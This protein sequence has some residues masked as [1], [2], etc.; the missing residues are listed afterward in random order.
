MK[1]RHNGEKMSVLVHIIHLALVLPQ[2]KKIPS[3]YLHMEETGD[4]LNGFVS[5]KQKVFFFCS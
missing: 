4:I 3:C 5:R 2:W 1:A